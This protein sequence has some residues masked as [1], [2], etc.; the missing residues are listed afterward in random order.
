[1][2]LSLRTRIAWWVRP[3]LAAACIVARISAPL[4][5]R[6]IDA[7]VDYGIYVDAKLL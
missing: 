5:G 3:A 2:T 4:A 6:W 7:I 1:M